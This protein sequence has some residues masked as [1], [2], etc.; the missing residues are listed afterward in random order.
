MRDFLKPYYA[1]LRCEPY[2]LNAAAEACQNEE[3][4]FTALSAFVTAP[5]LFSYVWWVLKKTMACGIKQL[6]FLARDG[7]VM[8]KIAVALCQKFELPV[9]CHYFCVSRYT[10]RMAAYCFRDDSAYELLFLHCAAMTPE[11]VLLRG[12]LTRAE[13]AMV[14]TALDIPLS[15]ANEPLSHS[16]FDRFCGRLRECDLFNDFV[17]QHSEAAN[18]RFVAYAKQNGVFAHDRIGIVDTGW[19]GSMQYTLSAIL[20]HLEEPLE[21]QGFY[22]GLY[23]TPAGA[24]RNTY[25]TF[26]FSPDSKL[27]RIVKFNN[28]LFECMCSAPH[29]MT[30][31]YEEDNNRR[32][33][34]LFSDD[35]SVLRNRDAVRE[36]LEVMQRFTMHLVDNLPR[37][38]SFT[39]AQLLGVTEKLLQR[40]MYHPDRETA[41]AYGGF[42][43]CDDVS[44]AYHQKLAV[45]MPREKLSAYLFHHRI[46]A[47]LRRKL[48]Q[49]AETTDLFWSYGAL[50]LSECR[51]RGWYRI[52]MNAWELL[53]YRIDRIKH[54]KKR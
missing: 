23:S 18:R 21:M 35:S 42:V 47:R 48:G 15:R 5:V 52:N 49:T 32:I 46:L 34:P 16:A 50:A 28:N 29:G 43:F 39:T 7:Y 26:Y 19:T 14:Y 33:V 53:R 51:C 8:H 36:Q 41:R 25:N 30:I 4:S 9:E 22:F 10:L 13:R 17:M 27:S 11:H 44:E 3:D 1:I 31:D 37:F 40:V 2:L 45:A 12:G 24:A 6:Y 54:K 20:R 38:E